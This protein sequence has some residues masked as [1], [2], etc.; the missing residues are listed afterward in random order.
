[1]INPDIRTKR[2][3]PKS[4][5]DALGRIMKAPTDGTLT[6]MDC[7]RISPRRQVRDHAERAHIDR[8]VESIKST[9]QLQPI[10]VMPISPEDQQVLN[11]NAEY[12]ILV[13]ERRWHACKKLGIQVSAI[14]RDR[15]SG[16][17]GIYAMLQENTQ[18]ADLTPFELAR[19]I[20]GLRDEFDESITNI[21]KLLGF[22]KSQISKLARLHDCPIEIED[23]YLE[24]HVVDVNTLYELASVY[25]RDQTLGNELILVARES[26]LTRGMVRDAVKQLNE[27]AEQETN[28][29]H[30]APTSPAAGSSPSQGVDEGEA[31]GTRSEKRIVDHDQ[32]A[33]AGPG[34][35]EPAPSVPAQ[36]QKAGIATPVSPAEDAPSPVTIAVSWLADAEDPDSREHGTLV[37]D[38][39]GPGNVRVKTTVGEMELPAHEVRLEG[40]DA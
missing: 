14:V 2:R 18:R 9:G 22:S 36:R 27:A 38:G 34:A 30:I 25:R 13:G 24:E 31:P 28:P 8:L 39:A 32:P 16:A 37:L 19:G 7:S 1:M 5:A 29:S 6:K 20:V 15:L 11:P 33:Q 12:V 26:K 10:Q 21:A 3:N 4:S 23:L 40:V 17:A 35:P